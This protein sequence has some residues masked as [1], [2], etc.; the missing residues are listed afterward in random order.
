MVTKKQ[1]PIVHTQKKSRR[2]SKHNKDRHQTTKEQSKRRKE[3]RGS[4]KQP[5]SH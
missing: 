4:T 1:K 3:Q 2:E 5:T